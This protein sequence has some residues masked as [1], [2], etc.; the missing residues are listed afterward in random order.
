MAKLLM[1]LTSHK[2]IE[3]DIKDTG[4]W[5][6]EFTEPYFIFAD[7]G[8]DIQLASPK[9]GEP[10]IDPRSLLTENITPH[11]R[12]FNDDKQAQNRFKNTLPLH[13]IN[14]D[15]YDAIFYP[16]G[17]GPMWDLA[18]DKDNAEL[19]INFFEHEKPV[20]A[21]CHGPAALIKAAERKPE[22]LKGKKVTA[23]SNMEEKG[24]GLYDHIPFKLEDRLK[25]LGAEYQTATIP[26]TS[27]VVSD[28]QLITGQNPASADRAAHALVEYLEVHHV[29]SD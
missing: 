6:G 25:E 9:G 7:K 19:L 21:V 5:L 17:H 11:N 8:Y 28:G 2:K 1:V 22:I 24:V 16:G 20:G 15:E 12:R 18:R 4:V 27:K 13:K 29:L 10:P 26:F 14:P 3:G 23:F